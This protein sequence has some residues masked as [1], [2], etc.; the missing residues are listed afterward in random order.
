MDLSSPVGF[1]RRETRYM[2]HEE[3]VYLYGQRDEMMRGTVINIS[4]SGLCLKVHTPLSNR[5]TITITSE[6][7]NCCQSGY[8]R[9]VK[10][11]ENDYFMVGLYCS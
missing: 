5:Q 10:K 2:T 9:W 8:V 11:A 4:D 3:V 6:L 7:P 1:L